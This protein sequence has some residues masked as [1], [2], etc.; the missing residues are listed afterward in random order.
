M[1]VWGVTAPQLLDCVVQAP[2]DHNPKE[3]QVLTGAAD[4]KG[5]N[6]VC[7]THTWG[8]VPGR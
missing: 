5:Q 2:A 7:C 3:A 8:L 1:G 4:G 6:A